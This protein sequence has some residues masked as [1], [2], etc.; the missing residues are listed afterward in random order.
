MTSEELNKRLI[1]Q[2]PKLEGAY[3]EEVSWQEGDHT[4]SH[5]VY[6]DVFTPYIRNSI[7]NKESGEI[8]TV[9]SYIEDTLNLED[10][11]ADEVISF[12]VLESIA[13]LLKDEQWVGEFVKDR[14]K[15]V[16]IE[17]G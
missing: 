16:L 13:E 3:T 6:G 4:G 7:E 1:E 5:T 15:K 10:D 9:F 2:F 8:A 12:S 11:Y 17:I 14:T